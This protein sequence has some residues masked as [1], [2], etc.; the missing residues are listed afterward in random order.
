MQVPEGIAALGEL[1]ALDSIASRSHDSGINEIDEREFLLGNLLGF[2]VDFLA[3][4]R[5]STRLN[6]SH[7]LTSR[8]PSS[9]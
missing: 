4:D 2:V 7:A 3:L 6:S 9:A 1:D 5:K 8:I